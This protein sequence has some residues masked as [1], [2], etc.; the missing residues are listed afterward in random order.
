MSAKK[1]NVTKSPKSPKTAKKAGTKAPKDPAPRTVEAD[2]PAKNPRLGALDAAAKVL[3]ETGT[4]MNCKALIE[5]MA[6]KG[7][8][9]SPAGKTPGATLYSAMTKEITTKGK[10]SRFAKV[11]RGLFALRTGR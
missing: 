8:W 11:E 3:G 4:P 9:T 5:A 7:Y 10:E 2:V 6:A 1:T